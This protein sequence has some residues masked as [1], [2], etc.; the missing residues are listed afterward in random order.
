MRSLDPEQGEVREGRLRGGGAVRGERGM[1]TGAG[2]R[3]KGYGRGWQGGE[4]GVGVR[5]RGEWGM[6]RGKDEG[7]L[8]Y[9]GG[10]GEEGG[11]SPAARRFISSCVCVEDDLCRGIA[12]RLSARVSCRLVWLGRCW[13]SFDASFAP[14]SLFLRI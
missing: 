9:E 12:W 8:G 11:A 2:E 13:Q 1:G 6:G 4:G 3:R 7:R 10:V 14:R 5:V